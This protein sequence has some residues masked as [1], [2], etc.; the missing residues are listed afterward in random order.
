MIYGMPPIM[1]GNAFKFLD[2]FIYMVNQI[3]LANLHLN[4]VSFNVGHDN[5]NTSASVRWLNNS[6]MTIGT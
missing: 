3:L 5:E 6:L 4:L 1:D 2:A